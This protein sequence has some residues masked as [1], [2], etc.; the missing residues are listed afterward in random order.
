MVSRVPTN[1]RYASATGPILPACRFEDPPLEAVVAAATRATAHV[2]RL[3]DDK[4]DAWRMPEFAIVVSSVGQSGG[5]DNK[6]VAFVPGAARPA[7]GER[8]RSPFLESEGCGVEHN[9]FGG[10]NLWWSPS[11]LVVAILGVGTFPRC[12]IALLPR[13]GA[14]HS[15]AS[16]TDGDRRDI[17]SGGT[18]RAGK[19]TP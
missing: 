12:I 2:C 15:F 7:V 17:Q 16:S 3:L 6:K 4:A 11:G 18:G 13:C 5:V 19:Q 1:D 14:S 8:L 9:A 10:G